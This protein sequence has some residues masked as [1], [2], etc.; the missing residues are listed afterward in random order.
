MMT[1]IPIE[2]SIWS[3]YLLTAFL[4]IVGFAFYDI[5][6]RRVPDRALVFFI[7][8]AALAPLIQVYFI[9]EYDRM[10]IFI[11][12]VV[13]EALMGALLGVFAGFGIILHGYQGPKS[14]RNL[15]VLVLGGVILAIGVIL[16]FL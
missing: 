1:G 3:A 2:N 14:R 10:P 11:W 9:L 16:C 5:F 8:L 12:P 6:H 7:P 15:L 13:T 4:V